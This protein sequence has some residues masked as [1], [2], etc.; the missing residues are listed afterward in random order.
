MIHNR[1]HIKRY[2]DILH[3]PDSEP[4][5]SKMPAPPPP[6]DGGGGTSYSAP[7]VTVIGF[8]NKESKK[9]FKA[10]MLSSD[11]ASTY[12]F[13]TIYTDS[14]HTDRIGSVRLDQLGTF[15]VIH[16]DSGRTFTPNT[17]YYWY[18]T[19]SGGNA[20]AATGLTSSGG[21]CEPLDMDLGI[22]H[23]TSYGGYEGN[24]LLDGK[25]GT[26][27]S[28]VNYSYRLLPI[29]TGWTAYKETAFYTN[30][31]AGTYTAEVKDVY[32]DIDGGPRIVSKQFIVNQPPQPE[33]GNSGSCTYVA[34]GSHMIKQIYT[35]LRT[36]TD[37]NDSRIV[38]EIY[39]EET[40]S[41][42]TSTK[43]VDYTSFER[44][45]YIGEGN[46]DP[47]FSNCEHAIGQ[48]IWSGCTNTNKDTYRYNGNGT[49][50]KTTETNSTE[51]GY[52]PLSF[53]EEV[54]HA[55]VYGG[56]GSIKVTPAGGTPPYRHYL[57]NSN[58]TQ[59][60]IHTWTVTAG[61]YT[62]TVKDSSNATIN[63]TIVIT[64][65]AQV[66]DDLVISTSVT[67]A[68]SYGVSDGKVKV[69]ATGS[70]TPFTYYI[71]NGGAW[72]SGST[73]TFS[74]LSAGTYEFKVTDSQG[75]SRTTT[76][77]VTQP[78]QVFDDL[79]ISTSATGATSYGVS[80]GKVKVNATG[81]N[82]PFTYYIKNGGAWVLGSTSTFS[83]LSAG[84]Y[85][86][87]VTDSQGFSRTTTETVTQPAQVVVATSG[88]SYSCDGVAKTI[89]EDVTLSSTTDTYDT[90]VVKAYNEAKAIV[91]AKVEN[92]ACAIIPKGNSNLIFGEECVLLGNVSVKSEEE[93]EKTKH[94]IILSAMTFN[95]STN[96]TWSI[97]KAVQ[98]TEVG[99]YDKNDN[100]VAIGKLN[101]PIS[102]IESGVAILQVDMEF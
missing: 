86:F 17:T 93:I 67:G 70:N 68:T 92:G 15:Y 63:K 51:C 79:V 43:S 66:F 8:C 75:F 1:P 38:D 52:V 10:K 77:T 89:R 22:N 56:N 76:E 82:T 37:P 45:R 5:A 64:Q 96:P 81:S 25:G 30:L 36:E 65:P 46:D 9:V 69:N 102:K 101:K 90:L 16:P 98:V 29:S 48:F 58:E 59:A 40:W 34:N 31:S 4:V 21:S 74:N 72:V 2:G 73:S 41:F 28:S 83:N 78:A 84:T 27:S 32:S 26:P 53:T 97:G 99:I 80:D 23:A 95:E 14:L 47:Y 71:K 35:Y 57:N 11:P 6:E 7:M 24:V 19:D 50:Q 85:E 60:N 3:T 13:V 62:V 55:S 44:G 54:T 12:G 20:P 91:M 88:Y 94:V 61:S 18:G 87:K 49:V 100:L 33:G 39:Q 42:N